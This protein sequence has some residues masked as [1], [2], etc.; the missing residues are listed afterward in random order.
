MA[1]NIKTEEELMTKA[2]EQFAEGKK[3]LKKFI[4]GKSPKALQDLITTT[5]KM[6]KAA[7]NIQRQQKHRMEIIRETLQK[8]C[9]EECSGN[10]YRC[11]L[12][13]LQ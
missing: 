1:N 7:T 11:A 5:W 6:E 8:K 2:Q 13:V 12:E 3:D 10:W 4:L 9:V